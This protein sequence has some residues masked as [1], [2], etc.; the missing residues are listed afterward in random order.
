R[1]PYTTLF[2]SELSEA[3]SRATGQR[4]FVSIA[5]AT[6]AAAAAPTLREQA[7]TREDEAKE[8]A[9]EDPLVKAALAVLA[10]AEIVHVR[11]PDRILP[12]G[13]EIMPANPVPA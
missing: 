10:G 4:W 8:R 12:D 13:V 7:K 3:L 11:E 2:R 6:G 9:K 5:R 1:V